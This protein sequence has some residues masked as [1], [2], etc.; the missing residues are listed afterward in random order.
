MF[1]P[2]AL[3]WAGGLLFAGE[4]GERMVMEVQL[5]IGNLP[6]STTGNELNTLFTQ[7]GEVTAVHLVTDRLTGGSKGYAYITMSAQSE[8]DRAVSMF[9]TYSLDGHPLKVGLTNRR[10]QR[11]FVTSY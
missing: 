1:S 2:P 8:A 4:S 9:N 6:S 7:A 11:G 10:E 5:Y 3:L